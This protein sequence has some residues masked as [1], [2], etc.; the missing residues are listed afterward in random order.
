MVHL[1][2]QMG[3]SILRLAKVESDNMLI[4]NMLTPVNHKIVIDSGFDVNACC[5]GFGN[6]CIAKAGITGTGSPN[7][8]SFMGYGTELCEPVYGAIGV[9]VNANG[10]VTHVGFFDSYT[11]DGRIRLLG[12]NQGNGTQAQ[13]SDMAANSFIYWCMPSDC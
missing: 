12:G 2:L 5:S 3:N 13:Y 8:G 10:I 1:R 9:Q 6:W 7:D 4:L 11:N